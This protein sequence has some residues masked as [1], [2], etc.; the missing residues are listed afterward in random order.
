MKNKVKVILHN[1]LSQMLGFDPYAIESFDNS[2]EQ[3]LVSPYVVDPCA[4]YRVWMV[5]SVIMEHQ[6][7]CDALAFLLCAV[8]VTR[9]DGEVFCVKYDQPYLP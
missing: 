3:T 4:H 5:Y 9:N 7:I 8:N 6:V 1:D 2:I